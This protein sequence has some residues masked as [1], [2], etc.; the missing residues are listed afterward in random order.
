MSLGIET[1]PNYFIYPYFPSF[2][3]GNHT[4]FGYKVSKY[5]KS[6]IFK[7]FENTQLRALIY[8]DGVGASF[9]Q[10]FKQYKGIETEFSQS[11]TQRK[12]GMN[13]IE[14]K[15]EASLT[16]HKHLSES[17][18]LFPLHAYA[19]PINEFYIKIGSKSRRNDID[20]TKASPEFLKH[21]LNQDKLLS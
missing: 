6:S 8:G 16:F 13:A 12:L 21:A 20:T 9:H 7:A 1:Q 14:I 18:N 2:I 5:P 19:D 4:F 3:Y 15:R 11:L 17:S 10:F